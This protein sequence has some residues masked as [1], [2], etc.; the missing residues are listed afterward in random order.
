VDVG[1][2]AQPI[3]LAFPWTFPLGTALTLGMGL[4]LAGRT[5]APV[6]AP[7]RGRGLREAAA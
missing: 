2:V 5:T 6:D 7:A 3:K 4:A 1:G